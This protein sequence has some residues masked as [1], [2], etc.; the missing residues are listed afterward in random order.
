MA[1]R[2]S[3]SVVFWH[4]DVPD[5]AEGNFKAKCKHCSTTISGSTK[6]TS[7]F[8]KE[9]KY[10]KRKRKNNCRARR[11][12]TRNRGGR[13]RRI[14]ERMEKEKEKQQKGKDKIE[15]EKE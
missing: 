12:K 2:K 8:D 1:S 15:E 6:S 10:I 14:K 7:N 4:F 3:I 9:V 5:N 13:N 11:T